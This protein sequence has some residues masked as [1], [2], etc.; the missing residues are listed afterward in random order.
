M[1]VAYL[2][3]SQTD[4]YRVPAFEQFEWLEHGFGTAR[5][6][7]WP[8]PARLSMVKQVHSAIVVAA[9]AAGAGW[10]GEGDALVASK[11]GALVGVRTADCV[12]VL[13]VDACRRAVA[14]VHAGWKGTSAEIVKCTISEMMVRFG[15]VP[16]D[17]WAA[18]GPAIGVCCYEVGP[19]VAG[20][21]GRWFPE[22]DGID[23][24]VKIDLTEVNRRQLV[25]AGVP[26]T[27]AFTGAPCTACTPTLDSFRRDREA[28]GRMI[29]AIGVRAGGVRAGV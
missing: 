5:S 7:A 23:R 2:K 8:D 25:E 28:A 11:P 1:Q 13:L 10:I 17:V 4:V 9:D 15:T 22:L 16:G 6:G 12:P 21:F 27:Q 20:R 24:H 26:A 14:A 29:A 3:D 19:E 18:I